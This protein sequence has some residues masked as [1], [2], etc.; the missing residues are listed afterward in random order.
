[1]IAPEPAGRGAAA[2]RVTRTATV[3]LELF[4]YY[5]FKYYRRDFRAQSVQF[6]VLVYIYFV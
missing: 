2:V 6:Q 5:L 3:V 4:K 1:M